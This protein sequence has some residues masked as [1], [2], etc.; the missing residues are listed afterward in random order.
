MNDRFNMEPEPTPPAKPDP[1]YA[2]IN[3]VAIDTVEKLKAALGPNSRVLLT[4][5]IENGDNLSFITSMNGPTLSLLGL[6]Q[7]TIKAVES[8]KL[9]VK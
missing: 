1:T 5:A 8:Q 3:A 6:L 2:Q 7:Y 4:I 9:L